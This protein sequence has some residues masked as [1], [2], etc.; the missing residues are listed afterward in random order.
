MSCW[1]SVAGKATEPTFVADDEP[2]WERPPAIRGPVATLQSDRDPAVRTLPLKLRWATK[3]DWYRAQGVLPEGEGEGDAGILVTTTAENGIDSVGIEHKL[4]A[5][6]GLLREGDPHPS[7][8]HQK[9]KRP[10]AGIVASRPR[11]RVP[12]PSPAGRTAPG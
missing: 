8:R 4:R 10:S 2:A 11:G 5:L 12:A 1:Q 3:L 9:A 6:L 7:N